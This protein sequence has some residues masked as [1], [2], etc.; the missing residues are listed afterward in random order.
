MRGRGDS[1][2]GSAFRTYPSAVPVAS[3][4]SSLHLGRW[5]AV[6]VAAVL[7]GGIS[8]TGGLL[9][10]PVDFR[11]P[12]PPKAALLYDSS[13]QQFAEI[14]SPEVR[15]PV[16]GRRIPRVMRQATVAAEDERYFDHQG[17]DPASIIRAAYKDITSGS[18]QGGSTITQQYVKNVYVGNDRTLVRKLREAALAY[19]LEQRRGKSEIL[20]SYLNGLYLG[21]GLYGVQAASLYYFGVPVTQLDREV[22]DGTVD[23]I[24]GLARAAMLAGI[25]PAPS[26]Y[27]PV[28]SW[29]NARKR[30]RYTL[31]RMVVNGFVTSQQA[32]AAYRRKLTIV[33]KT[34]PA[35][36]VEFPEYTDMVEAALRNN[37][38]EDLLFRGGLRVKT[39]LDRQLQQAVVEA[40][41][42]VL[43][44]ESDPQAAVV[45][46]DPSTGNLLALHTKRRGGYQRK[47]F[48]LATNARRSTGSTIKPF[49]LAAAM[50]DSKGKINPGTRYPAPSCIRI[51]PVSPAY[52]KGYRPCNFAE[53][54]PASGSATL[55]RA[56]VKSYNTTYAKL[57]DDIGMAKVGG[58]AEAA[59][60]AWPRAKDGSRAAHPALALGAEVTPLSL[61]QG[62]ATLA[63]KGVR[64]NARAVLEVRAGGAGGF[65]TGG[66]V[67]VAEA[68]PKGKAVIPPS[69]AEAVTDVL[70][71]VV[72]PG[73]TAPRAKQP[74]PVFGKTGTSQDNRDAWFVGCRSDGTLCLATWMG[75]DD[76][77]PMENVNGVDQVTG[78]SLPA[79][80]FATAME[81]YRVLVAQK[82]APTSVLSPSAGSGDAD[83]DNDGARPTRGTATEPAVEPTR[84]AGQS[85]PPAEPT[86]EPPPE[87]PPPSEPPEEPP[88]SDNGPLP[89]LGAAPGRPEGDA[90]GGDGVGAA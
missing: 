13:G 58:I 85:P 45:A 89:T 10:A 2:T 67:A 4:L 79:T 63:A 78:G 15:E 52:P 80:I 47:G 88:P 90:A 6:S 62:F 50:I 1:P 5:I 32:D 3:V 72:E 60:L 33:K 87:E 11:L 75:Y 35:P 46:I 8:F 44:D 20:T 83:G 39:A 54:G 40:V 49:T 24:L 64:R 41:G 68:E 51:R 18:R 81:R 57:G 21:N 70:A 56:L 23:P 55:R 28:K 73:G 84:G 9:A 76:N 86:S 16:D 31:S 38:G 22:K 14:R 69:V 30:Q 34:R 53:S 74:F 27:N 71:G 42:A 65:E 25:A 77:R 66:E 82:D 12:P 36:P 43:P 29:E 61:A 48:N 7:V 59:G 19:R 37:L 17:V 26:S